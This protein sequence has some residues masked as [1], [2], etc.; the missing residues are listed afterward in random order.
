MPR[1][2][3]LEDLKLQLNRFID[4][5]DRLDNK[6]NNRI[7][8]S[9]IVATLFMGFGIFLLSEVTI[10]NNILFGM[11]SIG[12]LVTEVIL[13]TITIKFSLDSYTLRN[14]YHPITFNPFFTNDNE[15]DNETIETFEQSSVENYYHLMIE[16]HLRA[17]QSYQVQNRQQTIGINHAQLTFLW[18]VL[19][20][21]VFATS[22]LL[23]FFPVLK[24][25]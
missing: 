12:A 20:I 24:P 7:S 11:I 22:V 10:Q 15:L 2:E 14:Y 4:L 21:P 23:T 13:T 5:K 8:M 16:E 9:G 17:I 6:A 1:E 18:S 25:F 19:M 3:F